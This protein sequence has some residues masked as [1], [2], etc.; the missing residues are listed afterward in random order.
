MNRRI[1]QPAFQMP[2]PPP[3]SPLADDPG[4]RLA[5]MY[6]RIWET[7]MRDLPFVNQSLSVEAVGFRRWR[8]DWVGALITPWFLNLF[9]LPGGGELWSDRPSGERC[10]IAFPVGELEFIADDDASREI[11]AYQYCA[12]I[13]QVGHF[14]TQEAARTTAEEVLFAVFAAPVVIDEVMP[15]PM[16]EAAVSQPSSS[17]RAFFRHVAGH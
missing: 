16:Q 15:L 6:R 13:T 9:V 17:R 4:A 5:A 2:Q 11:P 8:G 7:S 10:A 14:A 12:L 1:R 3:A